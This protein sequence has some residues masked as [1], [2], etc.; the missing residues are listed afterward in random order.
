MSHY[1]VAVIHDKNQNIDELLAPY[2]EELKVEPY[3][4]YT[5]QEAI[6]FAKKYIPDAEG[7]SDEACWKLMARGRE[8][9]D[10]GN[11]YS[12]RNPN[13]KWDWYDIGGRFY[14]VLNGE[15][16]CRVGDIDT[17]PNP[18]EY[19]E[20]LRFWDVA[21]D[22]KPLKEGE[23]KEDF[24]TFFKEEY[25]REQYLNRETFARICTTFYT[26]AVITP[27]GKWHAPGDVGW[28]GCSSEEGDEFRTWVLNYKSQ[29][30]NGY[31]DLIMTIVDCHI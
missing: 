16:E 19:K 8:T 17:K 1:A 22:H 26:Y 13:A 4:E 7:K 9:D 24:E 2:W 6:D 27:D 23:N 29:F 10:E 31:E 11:I 15:A 18:K 3:V 28:F 21:I 12:T 14:D 30:I 25:Y 20:Q 5:R